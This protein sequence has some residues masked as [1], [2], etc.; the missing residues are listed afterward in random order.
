MAGLCGKGI[1]LAYSYDL[2]RATEI[3]NHIGAGHLFIKVGHGPHFFPETARTMLSRVRT[4]G[5][6]PLAWVQI[7]GYAPQDA[8][9]AILAA[10]TLGYE[11][12]VLRL[13]ASAVTRIQIQPL[14]QALHDVDAPKQR[15]YLCSPPLPYLSDPRVVEVLATVCQGGWMPQIG[16]NWGETP[17]TLIDRHIYQ[18]LGDLSLVWGKSPDVY[19]VL[20]PPVPVKEGSPLPETFIPWLE[21]IAQ[22]GIDFFSVFHAANTESA[23]W[24]MLDAVNISCQE[25]AERPT[26]VEASTIGNVAVPQPVYITVS[27]SNTVWGIISRH[28]LNKQQ[29]WTWNAHLWDSRNLPRDPDYLQEG[30]R[31]RVK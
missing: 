4:V 14:A 27:T 6:Y 10:L 18:A 30:W 1:W 26:V 23:L 25:T 8:S 20:S 24:P 21:G 9:K 19:P 29:F 7:T 15:L 17:T 16:D 12:V 5:L 11:A 3:A 13:D 31:I 2:Q 28:G 22:H